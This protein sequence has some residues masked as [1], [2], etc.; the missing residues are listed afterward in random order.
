MNH[1]S[2]ITYF[3]TIRDDTNKLEE[4]LSTIK[5]D[6]FLSGLYWDYAEIL[7]FVFEFRW[8]YRSVKGFQ[9]TTLPQVK[10]M[11]K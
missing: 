4:V 8:E 1:T 6:I 5:T 9:R 7:M 2:I 3:Y 11:E 10:L